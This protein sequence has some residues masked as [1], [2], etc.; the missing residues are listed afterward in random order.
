MRKILRTILLAAAGLGAGGAYAQGDALVMMTWGG[1]WQK[2]FDKIAADYQKKTGKQVRVVT[3]ASADA[4]LARLIAQKARPEVDVWTPNMVNYG[5]ALPAGVL[6]PLNVSALPNAADVPK[7]L[8]FSH[9]ITTWVSQRG[10]F[11]RKDLVPF[12]PTKWEDL[13]D[14]RLKGKMAGPA[15]TFDPG[16]FPLMAAVINGG[17]ERNLDPGFAKLKQLRESFVAFYTNNPQ[18]IRMLEA[19]EV[20]LVAWGVLPNV[21]QHLGPD[22]KFGFVIPKPAFVAETPMTV[23]AGTAREKDALA[24]INYAL[25]PEVQSEIAAAFGSAPAN[26]KATPPP[27]LQKMLPDVDSIYKVD[28]EYLASEMSK[29]I[30]RYDREIMQR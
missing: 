29:I 15:A 21:I 18:S 27:I 30:D 11:Y 4:G 23:V 3:Q 8:Q 13:W 12:E 5:R 14:P 19:G 1:V 7:S 9:G 25:S 16:Y 26:R 22:S 10:I 24:F 17:N 6:A 20:P 28:Y 2:T